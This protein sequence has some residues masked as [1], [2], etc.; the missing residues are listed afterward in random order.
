MSDHC[1]H[2][3]VFCR[4]RH[5]S[6]GIEICIIV[7]KSQVRAFLY[8]FEHLADC[9]VLHVQGDLR[10][11]VLSMQRNTSASQHPHKS[12]A[13][14]NEFSSLHIGYFSWFTI[15]HAPRRLAGHVIS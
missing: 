1:F 4:D 3:L 14:E 2:T 6:L 15:I 13:E 8:A 12:D 5:K 10:A 11:L 7:E 9:N